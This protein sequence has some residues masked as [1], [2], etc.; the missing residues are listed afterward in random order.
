MIEG[1]YEFHADG[2][3]LDVRAG[4]TVLVPAGSLHG[5]RAGPQG[6]RG[7]VIYPGR[8]ER[9]FAEVAE[10]GG[11]AAIGLASAARISAAQASPSAGPLPAR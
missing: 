5:F 4:D 6:D 10:A 7:L 8:Q 3:W 11:P 9:W 2:R 1:T